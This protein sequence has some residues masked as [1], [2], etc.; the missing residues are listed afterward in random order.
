MT[1]AEWREGRRCRLA[2]SDGNVHRDGAD[3]GHVGRRSPRVGI[4]AGIR[5]CAARVLLLSLASGL[6]VQCSDLGPNAVIED[7]INYMEAIASSTKEQIFTNMLRLR[8]GDV[9]TFLDVG[10]IITGYTISGEASAAVLPFGITGTGT[11][12]ASVGGS[13]KYENR[14]T[15]TYTPLTGDRFF[16]NLLLPIPPSAV[17]FVLHAGWPL[18]ITMKLTIQEMNGVSNAVTVG[19]S[20][21]PAE[22]D[23]V[24]LLRLLEELQN[25]RAMEIRPAEARGAEDKLALRTMLWL[26]KEDLPEDA[27]EKI[28]ALRTLLKLDPDATEFELVYGRIASNSNEIVVMTRSILQILVSLGA[29][30]D[31]PEEHV[32][33]GRTLPSI[34]GAGIATLAVKWGDEAPADAYVVAD[35]K[36]YRFWIEDTDFRSKRIFTFVSILFALAERGETSEP[37]ILTIPTR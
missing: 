27:R 16:R 37:P 12:G 34:Q 13:T 3:G 11:T 35:Y 15:V 1:Y 5:A 32:T 28:A 33:S 31:V 20:R 18:D 19:L 29:E 23:F 6:I 9:P 8:Y 36:G 17:F 25:A 22:P 4:G 10:Q 2:P 26:E 21:R 7:R 24:E 30:I 14:P